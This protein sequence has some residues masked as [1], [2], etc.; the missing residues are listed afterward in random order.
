M[1]RNV[2]IIGGL[3]VATIIAFLLINAFS[4]S[5]TDDPNAP[6]LENFERE[7]LQLESNILEM[8]VLYAEKENEV[9]DI[10]SLLEEK[11]DQINFLEQQLEKLEAS[12]QADKETIERLRNQLARAK[13]NLTD[14]YKQQIDV[15]V[16]DNGLL[17]QVMDSLLLVVQTR[18]SS[19]SML[20]SDLTAYQ[21][22]LKDCGGD[23]PAPVE[24]RSPPPTANRQPGFRAFDFSYF[25]VRGGE[26]IKTKTPSVDELETLKIC[27]QIEGYQVDNQEYSFYLLMR[28][29][30]GETFHNTASA[31]G[32]FSLNG[33]NAY[34]TAKSIFNYQ[35]RTG[36]VCFLISPDDREKF[37]PG[38]NNIFIYSDEKMIGSKPLI[39]FQ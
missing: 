6:T 8:E 35:G 13:A 12:G 27:V 7:I 19:L 1:N 16:A 22:A 3:I 39:L 38:G 33:S 18:D 10:K 15:L 14:L 26:E 28:K 4:G 29:P 24:N 23:T 31:S 2:L 20:N 34:F 17:T 37:I 21:Q 32:T 25:N 11:Y 30:S 36:E 5:G 9:S